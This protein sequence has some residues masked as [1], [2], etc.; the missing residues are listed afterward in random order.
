MN[1]ADAHVLVIEDNPDNVLVVADLLRLIGVQ[2]ITARASGRQGIKPA[3][4]LPRV[5]LI[6]LDIQLPYEDGY[7]VLQAIR[8]HPKLQNTQGSPAR[9]SAPSC[10]FYTANWVKVRLRHA[11]RVTPASARH[12][13]Q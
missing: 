8:T 11:T 10:R 1:P 13:R 5:D 3:E 12:S 7:Q 9:P 4:S 2:Y 6:L